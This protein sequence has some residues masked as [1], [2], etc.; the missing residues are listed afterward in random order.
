MFGSLHNLFLTINHFLT[1]D[2]ENIAYISNQIFSSA[3][4]KEIGNQDY[5]Q[6]RWQGRPIGSLNKAI[7]YFESFITYV[8]GNSSLCFSGLK[9]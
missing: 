8:Y 7:V 4:K 1:F 9:I 3:L 5:S 6:K 2:E